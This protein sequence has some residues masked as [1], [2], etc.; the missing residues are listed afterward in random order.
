MA[1]YCGNVSLED[2]E[3]VITLHNSFS[4]YCFALRIL[5]GLLS[6]QFPEQITSRSLWA[7][8]SG[9]FGV[10]WYKATQHCGPR[11]AQGR[12]TCS[13]WKSSRSCH[14]VFTSH[15]HRIDFK[16]MYKEML[17]HFFLVRERRK[18]SSFPWWHIKDPCFSVTSAC[19]PPTSLSCM[20][21]SWHFYQDHKYD[22]KHSKQ[23]HRPLWNRIL[24]WFLLQ[25]LPWN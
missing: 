7:V 14:K 19:S 6:S 4:L 2:Y 15:K 5:Y 25:L 21:P 8:S 9:S 20:E 16:K 22:V 17:Y 11:G 23:N 18:G 10:T 3:R 12:S 24:Q 1:Q 13:V